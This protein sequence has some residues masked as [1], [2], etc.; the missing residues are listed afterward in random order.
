MYCEDFS[1][2]SDEDMSN[3]ENSNESMEEYIDFDTCEDEQ[4]LPITEESNEFSEES[5]MLNI[6]LKYTLVED[7]TNE[8]QI[9]IKKQHQN[10]MINMIKIYDDSYMAKKEMDMLNILNMSGMSPFIIDK[11]YDKKFIILELYPYKLRYLLENN[12]FKDDHSRN[13]KDTIDNIHKY[14]IYHRNLNI[15]N[16]FFNEK[17]QCMLT[18]FEY[19]EYISHINPDVINVDFDIFRIIKDHS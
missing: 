2:S 6:N 5:F 11:N 8:Y 18:N 3:D 13:L 10:N 19:Y 4:V 15:D 12:L 1:N 17:N 14:G 7:R 9:Y 16:I